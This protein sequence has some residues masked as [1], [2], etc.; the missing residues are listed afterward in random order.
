MPNVTHQDD[1]FQD[2]V[3][4]RAKIKLERDLG[5]EIMAALADSKPFKLC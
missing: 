1:P 5:P 2:S 4:A 3:K